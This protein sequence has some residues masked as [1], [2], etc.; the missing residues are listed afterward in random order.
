MKK[1][2]YRVK[3]G[4]T[5]ENDTKHAAPGE[6]VDDLP[7]EAIEWLRAGGHIEPYNEPLAAREPQT[8]GSE[9]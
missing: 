3:D 7:V 4:L 8:E 9:N 5:Y 2:Q 6:I 1:E